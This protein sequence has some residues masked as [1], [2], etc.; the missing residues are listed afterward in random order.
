MES[1]ESRDDEFKMSDEEEKVHKNLIKL[2][3]KIYE[4]ILNKSINELIKISND[5]IDLIKS[6]DEEIEKVIQEEARLYIQFNTVS[7]RVFKLENESY[8]FIIKKA[9]D[10][11]IKKKQQLI[12]LLINKKEYTLENEELIKINSEIKETEKKYIK[13]SENTNKTIPTLKEEM[14]KIKNNMT[15]LTIKIDTMRKAKKIECELPF[16]E[17]IDIYLVFNAK[18]E[19]EKQLNLLK[20][21]IKLNL[22]SIDEWYRIRLKKYTDH[23]KDIAKIKQENDYNNK[24]SFVREGKSGAVIQFSNKPTS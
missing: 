23:L 16:I 3:P 9:L 14:I 12:T 18:Q 10:E 24:K 4:N 19:R 22:F 8:T 21:L 5:K 7:K 15:D 1:W 20:S 17:L 11:L 13:Y 2:S 6:R